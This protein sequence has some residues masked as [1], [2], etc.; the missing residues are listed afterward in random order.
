MFSAV[1]LILIYNCFFLIK[2][3]VNVKYGK[4]SSKDVPF[5]NTDNKSRLKLV[6]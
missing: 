6:N 5:Y 4:C 1:N 2:N 3:V